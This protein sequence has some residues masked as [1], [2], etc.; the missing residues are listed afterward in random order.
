MYSSVLA[1]AFATAGVV[2]AK[3]TTYDH[4]VRLMEESPLV[5]THIDLPQILRSL[6][7]RACS[8]CS[9]VVAD[10]VQAEIPSMLS[11]G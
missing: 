8:R 6:S 9:L 7:A 5:D 1:L 3:D 11:L 4:A 2:S 10:L